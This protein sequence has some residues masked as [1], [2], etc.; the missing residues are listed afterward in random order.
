VFSED[1]TTLLYSTYF[2]GSYEDDAS[3]IGVDGYGNCY[4]GGYTESPNFPLTQGAVDRNFGG[5]KEAV[6]AKFH[7]PA[8]GP[9]ALL[10]KVVDSETGDPIWN[11]KLKLKGTKNVKS[12]KKSIKSDKDGTFT[13]EELEPGVY[14]LIITKSGYKKFMVK[15]L[16]VDGP[17]YRYASLIKK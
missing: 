1:G 10:G 5:T 7:V 13:I 14:K 3:L 17:S 4:I 15:K 2:G 9:T 12:I 6:V 8:P 16:Y 11:A